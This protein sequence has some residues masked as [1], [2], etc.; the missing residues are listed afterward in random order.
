MGNHQGDDNGRGLH[1]GR[2]DGRPGVGAGTIEE[3]SL[4]QEGEPPDD[5]DVDKVPDPV[6]QPNSTT[7]GDV[8]GDFI[9][10]HQKKSSSALFM[11]HAHILIINDTLPD[12][13]VRFYSTATLTTLLSTTTTIT[14]TVEQL[15]KMTKKLTTMRKKKTTKPAG[16]K[17]I[18]LIELINS[19]DETVRYGV[20]AGG[21][22]VLLILLFCVYKLCCQIGTEITPEETGIEVSTQMKRKRKRIWRR[23]RSD[24]ASSPGYRTTRSKEESK[25]KKKS[26]ESREDG[27]VSSSE[28]RERRHVDVRQ[29]RSAESEELDL[30]N[31]KVRTT[32]DTETV[33]GGGPPPQASPAQKKNRGGGRVQREIKKLLR[34]SREELPVGKMHRDETASNIL[35]MMGNV[36]QA[37]AQPLAPPPPPPPISPAQSSAT[38]GYEEASPAGNLPGAAAYGI[39]PMW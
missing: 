7:L 31:Y 26:S 5:D 16:V 29:R 8:S 19:L 37:A 34:K 25:E 4:L 12:V 18:D 32:Q 21:I 14:P 20:F 35:N 6:E 1:G 30:Y 23:A 27:K 15:T 22:L 28:T 9:P 10:P 17:L 3:E 36:P 11:S 38:P 24:S 2:Q 33:T 13:C 39:Q